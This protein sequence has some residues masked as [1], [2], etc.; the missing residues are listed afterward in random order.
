MR[1]AGGD[2]RR[3]TERQRGSPGVNL[4]I[5]GFPQDLGVCWGLW[6]LQGLKGV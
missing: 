5:T 2:E 3:L 6:Q 4:G 1:G